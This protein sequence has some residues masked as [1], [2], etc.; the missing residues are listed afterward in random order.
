MEGLALLV[1]EGGGDDVALPFDRVNDAERACDGEEDLDGFEA[2]ELQAVLVDA[3][4]VDEKVRLRNHERE[5]V[6]M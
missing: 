5:G 6:A 4:G 2:V 3:E 1:R